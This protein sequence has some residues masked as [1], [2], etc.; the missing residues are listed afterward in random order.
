MAKASTIFQ[1]ATPLEERVLA[2][3][4][5]GVLALLQ[6]LSPAERARHRASVRRMRELMFESRWKSPGSPGLLWPIKATKAQEGAGTAAIVLCGTAEDVAEHWIEA[7]DILALHGA[8]LELPCKAEL[9]DALLRRSPRNFRIVQRLLAAGAVV[10]PACDEYVLGLIDLPQ[11]LKG[12]PDQ[13]RAELDADPGLLAVIPRM[14]EVEGN[15]DFS[16]ASTDKYNSADN[17][18]AAHLLALC[19]EGR[20]GRAQLLDW[21]LGALE[22]DWPQY[23]SGWFK[24]FHERLAP[25]PAELAPH[26]ARYLQLCHSRIP[27]TVTLALVA[28]DTLAKARAVDIAAIPPALA[29]V[30][31]TGAKGQV[32]TALKLLDRVVA[33]APGC[34]TD[35]ARV[36]AAALVHDAPPLQGKVLQRLERWARPDAL[37]VELRRHLP[38]IA[39]SLRPRL[40]ALVGDDSPAPAAATAPAAQ[41]SVS[42]PGVLDPSRALAPPADLDALVQAIA[43]V[44]EN[45][46]DSDAFEQ[47]L[48]ALVAAAP[49]ADADR[50]RFGPVRK[51]IAKLGS[52]VALD[53][54][55]LLAFVLDGVRLK[56]TVTLDGW[57][58]ASAIDAVLIARNAALVNLAA[59]GKRLV[60]LST[61]THRR[62]FIAP[63]ELVRRTRAH[64][65]AG[66]HDAPIE[67]VLALLR[68][69]PGATE[70]DRALARGLADTPFARAL[71]YALGDDVAPGPHVDLFC[72]AARIRHPGEDDPAT[73]AAYGD[74]GPDGPRAARYAW[75]LE[76]WTV[77]RG[78]YVDLLVHAPP[79][80]DEV[81]D[82]LAQVRHPAAGPNGRRMYGHCFVAGESAPLVAWSATILPSDTGAFFAEAAR[83]LGNNLDEWQA[84]WHHAAYLQPLLD[85]TVVAGEMAHLALACALLG[86][87]PG[88]AALA[89]DA[90][91]AMH[92]DGRLDAGLL[93]ATLRRLLLCARI[94]PARLRRS[95]DAA[96]RLEPALAPVLVEL[97]ADCVTGDETAPRKDLAKLVELLH[98]LLAAGAT[99]PTP[100]RRD[101][102]AR[103]AFAGTAKSLQKKV[104]ALAPR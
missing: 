101:A 20:F 61:P 35:A 45:P 81:G 16:L 49:I 97:L 102:L 65:D 33:D 87:E 53:L 38:G 6:P 64:D 99:P 69:P 29:P 7:E 42:R 14:F 84:C 67:Q 58:R 76:H 70:A 30:L 34:A 79:R 37:A 74:L 25:T 50:A 46:T 41:A 103:T 68:L 86:K 95:L 24:G 96:L 5:D 73:L 100:A 23:R 72:A 94:L 15:A 44:F 10:R 48:G 8:G 92:H 90:L 85:P 13:F 22:R 98:E 66:V 40:V 91:V 32:E 55:H 26:A 18:W 63:A 51:R 52:A 39:P 89:V 4:R 59:Q 62:G 56:A 21:T 36:A 43:H 93:G 83:A 60:P 80:A 1:P 71:R 12:R 9:A 28:L 54:G 19:D 3:D 57:G 88:R 27:P 104:L 75:A 47:A 78:S 77:E 31:A 2:G 82:R 17:G 11:M